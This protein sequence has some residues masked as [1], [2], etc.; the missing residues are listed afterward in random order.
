M[1]V[2][3]AG[4]LVDK[5]DECLQYHLGHEFIDNFTIGQ[6][7]PDQFKDLLKRIP[8]ASVRG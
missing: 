7:S 5:R 2:F 1:K 8:E 3:G 4:K 6:E